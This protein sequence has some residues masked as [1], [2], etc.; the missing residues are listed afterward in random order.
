MSA[1]VRRNKKQARSIALEILYNC[2]VDP[3]TKQALTDFGVEDEDVCYMSALV[4][5]LVKQALSG[6]LQAIH[7]LFEYIGEDPNTEIKQEELRIRKTE[8]KQK[9]QHMRSQDQ[10]LESKLDEIKRATEELKQGSGS[11][12]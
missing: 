11:G 8:L 7:T 12:K 9:R 1:E 10:L 4:M 3:D 5:I 2:E 6:N